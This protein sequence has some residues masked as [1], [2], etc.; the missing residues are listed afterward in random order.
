MRSN[1]DI[2]YFWLNFDVG[3]QTLLR[4]YVTAIFRPNLISLSELYPLISYKAACPPPPISLM[5]S[6]IQNYAWG[7]NK[8]MA[9]EKI[10]QMKSG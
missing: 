2:M 4:K 10:E 6:A 7:I 1:F 5:C 9:K 8:T 3:D